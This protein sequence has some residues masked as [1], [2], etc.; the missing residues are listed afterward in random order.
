MTA[1]IAVTLILGFGVVTGL[2]VKMIQSA[3]EHLQSFD[4]TLPK[5]PPPEPKMIPTMSAFS[6]VIWRPL[7]ASASRAAVMPKLTPRV[8]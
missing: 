3:V 8:M 7:S 1:A 6:S 4:I 5:P 2:N